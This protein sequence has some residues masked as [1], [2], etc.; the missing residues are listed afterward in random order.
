MRSISAAPPILTGLTSTRSDGA[1]AWMTA[2]WLAPDPNSGSRRTTAR[3]TPGAI[4]LSSSSHLPLMLHSNEMKPVTLPPG[5][6]RLSTKPAPTASPTP[7]NTVGTVRLTCRSGPRVVVPEAR[8][9]S[10]VSATSSA[11]YLRMRS[12]LPAPQRMSM[13][14]L[15]PSVQP[16]SCRP[17]RNAARRGCPSGPSSA[18][19]MST[20]TRRTRSPCCARAASGQAAAAPPSSVMKSRRLLIRLPRRLLH[21][22]IARLRPA[23]NLIDKLGRPPELGQHARPIGHQA[24]RFDKLACKMNRR[25]SQTDRQG[26]DSIPVD[27][28]KGVPANINCVHSTIERV[29]GG[30]DILGPPEFECRDLKTK[31]AGRRLS[32]T[33]FQH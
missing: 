3:V 28:D 14:M 27:V 9:T 8:M 32:C 19:L 16:N 31:H 1:T 13:R 6:A 17:L 30:H 20:L 25:Q 29:E 15:R 26:I 12:G 22:D 4:S 23:Q 5:R 21:G 33:H 24:S 18:T 7:V 10:G 11:A 2:N